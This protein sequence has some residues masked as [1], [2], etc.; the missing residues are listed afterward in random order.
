MTDDPRVDQLLEE[1]LEWGGSPEEVCRSCPELLP[2]VRSGLQRL[3]LL[4]DEVS[5]LFPPSDPPDTPAPATPLTAELPVIRGYE[6]Q[7]V[8]GR[9]GMGV[10]YKAW[11]LRLNRPVALKMLLAGPHAAPEQLE[12]FLRE[13]EAEAGLCHPNVVQVYDVGDVDGR[14][15]LAMELVE[16]GSLAQK[17]A[18]APLPARQAA[19]LVAVV[20]EAIQVAHQSGIVHRDLTPANVLLT[21]DGIPKVTDFGLARRLEGGAGLTLTGAPMGTPSY[22]AP[23]QARGDKGALGPATDVYALGA[24]L[25]ECLTGRPPFRAETATA[26]LQQVVADE[27]VSPARLNRRV[28]RDLETICLKCLEKDRHRRYPSAA[29]LADD[30]RRF[31]HGEPIAARPAGWPE[32]A[33]KWA[34]RRP[35]AAVLLATSLL[36]VIALIGGSLWLVAQRAQQ[37]EAVEAD[38]KESAALRDGARWEDGR[39]ALDRA[40][41]RLGWA[42]PDDLRRR[43]GQARRDLEL[44]VRL[45][46]IRLKRVTGGELDFYKARAD[47][48]YA[49][50]FREAGLGVAD[51]P[52]ARLADNIAGSAVREALAATVYDWAVCAADAPRR[53]WLLE[54]ARQTDGA[55]DDWRKRALDPAVWDDER[56]LTELARTAP[57][58][59]EPA[60]LL[61]ALGERLRAV[62]GDAVP[63]LKLA[64][65][66]HPADFWPNLIL[67][68]A[69][70]RTNPQEAAG[71]YRAALASRPAAAVGYCAVGD[72]LQLQHLP[73]QAADYYEKALRLDP[74]YAR[75]HNNVGDV[76][77]DRGRRDEAI[78]SYETALRLDP[79]YAWPHV[80]LAKLLH[81]EGRVDESEDHYRQVLR[82]DPDNLEALRGVRGFL[83]AKGRGEEALLGWGKALEANPPSP[84]AWYGYAELCLFLGKEEEYCR[85]R[86]A[87][88]DRFGATASPFIAEPV[89]RACLLLPITGDEL[90]E[91][92]ALTDRAAAAKASTPEWIY[93]YFLFAKGLAEYRRGR[94]GAAISV[95]EGDAGK[96][97]RPA[98]LLVTAMARH[99]LGHEAEARKT[100]AAA[101]LAFDWRAR[102]ADNR[103]VWIRHILRREAEAMIVPDLPAFL[104]GDHRPRD[105]DERLCFLGACQFQGRHAA[106]ARL[107]ADAFAADPK[108][109]EDVKAETRYRAACSA[110][111]AGSGGG[112]DGAGLS[113]PERARWRQQAREWLRLD[114][115]AWKKWLEAATP[116]DR[117]EAQKP[118]AR[119]RENP[120]LAGLRE[121]EALD[122]L[123]PAE[124]QE[125][126]ALWS[127]L[128]AQLKRARAPK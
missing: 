94:L 33:A 32:R 102:R 62:G 95:M 53:R 44:V 57:A 92:A 47:R 49:E 90:R 15:Y 39:L 5:A 67:G 101:V 28:P 81:S 16:G 120:D 126:R 8:L 63:C 105:N 71:Y 127:D 23:E 89:G 117:A 26:T 7:G 75:A 10:V 2:Q 64:Q 9:G 65:Q 74:N 30:L 72:A 118:L 17:L 29:A 114:L 27:A 76:L 124:R 79:D 48:E 41:A 107:Y 37:R 18:G 34:R 96:V 73:D 43:V 93:R 3:R 80:N 11:H 110:A 61:L 51:A 21:A 52:A 116:A 119:W 123:P 25:Y 14:P 85:A 86:R 99:R 56:A 104:R 70:L 36:L 122:K 20:A 98:P 66:E 108:L 22:M 77:R 109:A 83:V 40:E 60:G 13:A 82:L 97:M 91:A 115:A 55:P 103:D 59:L 111:V 88:L 69:M 12:R 113:E 24:I 46:A 6:V 106:A 4:E 35:A 1:L 125:C 87:L 50:A 78:E 68:N 128:D 112:A 84:D 42:G 31:D 100:L 54:A 45:E 38:L 19:A 58:A 121:P